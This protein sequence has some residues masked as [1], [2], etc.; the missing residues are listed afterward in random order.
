MKNL[1]PAD[2]NV[3]SLFRAA[4][5]QKIQAERERERHPRCEFP[6]F[7]LFVCAH[8]WGDAQYPQSAAGIQ[9]SG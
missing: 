4:R 3:G 5:F 1:I 6:T 2:Y 9:I 7:S 8:R